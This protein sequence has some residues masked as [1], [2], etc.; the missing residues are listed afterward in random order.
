LRTVTFLLGLLLAFQCIYSRPA[1]DGVENLE[2]V[3]RDWPSATSWGSNRLD[4]FGRGTD[5]ALWHKWWDG[6]KWSGW[7]S[8]GG[9]IFQAPSCTS[10]G[11]N[12]IDCF[13]VGGSDSFYHKW[14]DGSKWSGWERLSGIVNEAIS[15]VTQ[16]ENSLDCFVRGTD[17][18]L[19]QRS[20]N[21][22][23][24]SEWTRLGGKLDSAPACVVKNPGTI[25]CFY[26][27]TDNTLREKTMQVNA[28]GTAAYTE[29][30]WTNL[31]GQ[32]SETP[33]AVY[34][35]PGKIE[36]M[37]RNMQGM[38]VRRFHVDGQWHGWKE[39]T[40]PLEQP[41]QAVRRKGT[42][43]IDYFLVNSKGN[44]VHAVI[45]LLE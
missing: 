27:G 40:L 9:V 18:A 23:K 36:V 12:R 28:D 7:E 29:G 8:L 5:N 13:V 37:A 38:M 3:V 26:R 39:T 2:G 42:R 1:P 11:P 19:Y 22:S 44:V 43:N 4:V 31:G 35:D 6:G 17:M 24:W 33:S 20:W 15:C 16:R 14:W 10:W 41:I 32:I 34:I 25:H 30:E 45:D 21:G